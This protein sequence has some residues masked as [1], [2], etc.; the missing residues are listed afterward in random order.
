MTA[1]S[2]VH[3]R[4]RVI[5]ELDRNAQPPSGWVQ[6]ERG[7]R[8]EFANLLELIALLESAREGPAAA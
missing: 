7:E 1:S 2:E 6:I 5:V 8:R 4:V 3:D